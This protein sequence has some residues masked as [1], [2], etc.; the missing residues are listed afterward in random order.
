M[1]PPRQLHRGGA[2][3]FLS[4]CPVVAVYGKLTGTGTAVSPIHTTLDGAAV[5]PTPRVCF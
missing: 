3:N 4:Q 5:R 2:Y 1:E